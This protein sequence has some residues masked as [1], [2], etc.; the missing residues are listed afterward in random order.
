MGYSHHW[1]TQYVINDDDFKHIINDILKIFPIVEKMGIV[2]SGP[3]GTG[4]YIVNNTCISFNGK[5]KCGHINQN[6]SM[7][8][9]T[10]DAKG[11][12]DKKI[13]TEHG[14]DEMFVTRLNT[15]ICGGNCM[16]EPFIFKKNN[17][18]RSK[19]LLDNEDPITKQFPHFSSCKTS[20]KP[21]DIVVMMVLIIIRHH[22]KKNV[23][24][25]SDGDI[26][27]WNDAISIIKYF[28]DYEDEFYL[29]KL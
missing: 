3:Q 14:V 5:E 28:F 9:P 16:F 27:N 7:G 2:L 19:T 11:V 8:W 26:N 15:R 1:R 23:Y 4:N 25:K 6:I 24:I 12:N 20:F 17:I 22:L 21:Y 18:Q 29:D 13:N 10:N